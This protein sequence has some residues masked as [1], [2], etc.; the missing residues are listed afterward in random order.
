MWKYF[1]SPFVCWRTIPPVGLSMYV[2]I[3]R[4]LGPFL[5]SLLMRYLCR[6]V[7]GCLFV[8][9][10]GLWFLFCYLHYILFV[11][12][13]VSNTSRSV[14]LFRME[15]LCLLFCFYMYYLLQIHLFPY[16]RSDASLYNCFSLST[17]SPLYLL[18][19]IH[20]QFLVSSCS[21]FL[22]SFS[23]VLLPPFKILLLNVLL[24][25]AIFLHFFFDCARISCLFLLLFLMFY[26]DLLNI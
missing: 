19:V 7:L 6:L 17:C 12:A 20:S 13:K 21:Y 1:V 26:C 8:V 24:N 9:L 10:H 5:L 25:F 3:Y 11:P 22:F 23:I 2:I 15:I 14:V 18:R 16:M 4:T